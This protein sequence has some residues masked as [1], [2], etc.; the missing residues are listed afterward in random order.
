M[1][2]PTVEPTTDDRMA[3]AADPAAHAHRIVQQVLADAEDAEASSPEDATGVAEPPAGAGSPAAIAS[4]VV[5]EVI[6]EQGFEPEDS[7]T[8][9]SLAVGGDGAAVPVVAPRQYLAMLSREE[10]LVL[11]PGRTYDP[12]GDAYTPPP[13]DPT[14]ARVDAALAPAVEQAQAP[15]PVTDGSGH[16][17]R[18]LLAA[19]LWAALVAGF[20]P[21]LLR[22]LAG[23]IDLRID[24]WGA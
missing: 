22:A 12:D 8:T 15:P 1:A 11:L 2:S 24:L 3:D 4:A 20:G 17:F 6:D 14:R 16:P 18:W 9:G 13:V 7:I 23:S 10:P 19:A 21:L 5:A